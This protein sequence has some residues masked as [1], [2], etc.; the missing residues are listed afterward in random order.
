MK[1]LESLSAKE[2]PGRVIIIGRDKSGKND[3]VVYAITGRSPSSQAR[4]LEIKSDAVWTRPTD[5][6]ILNKGNKDLLVYPSILLSQGIAVSN[7]KQ[8]TDI[9]TCL[10]YSK[11]P[12]EI[13]AVALN[14]WE[15]EPDPPHFTPRISGCVLPLSKAALAVIKRA[16]D[17]S[18][19]RNVFEIPLIAGM[20][21][22]ITTYK[23]ENKDP[24]PPCEEEPE[25]VRITEIKA[26]EVADTVYNAM[27][28]KENNN[29]FRVSVACVFSSD[30]ISNK[31]EIYVINKHERM[32]R[33]VGKNK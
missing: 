7:G 32:R 11:N 5:E 12:I 29:D 26:D 27:E 16:P 23:G 18:S 8:T 4:K 20:G 31:Y 28:P 15:Y 33:E 2:Y 19:V 21:K 6:D 1:G 30:L 3:V 25:D 13:L 14:K 10:N 24:L 22:M 9:R 17:G